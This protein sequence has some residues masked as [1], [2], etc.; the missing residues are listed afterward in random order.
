MMVIGKIGLGSGLHD[1]YLT[2]DEQYTHVSL[3]CLVCAP[4]LIGCPIDM[5]DEFTLNL[6]TND[7][8]LEVSQ[9]LLGQAARRM[10]QDGD[11][12][13]WAKPMEDGL[14]VVGFFNRDDYVPQTAAVKLSDLKLKGSCVVRD[15]WRQKDLGTFGDQFSTEVPVHGVVLVRVKAK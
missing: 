3:W 11:K 4:L 2:P 7:E 1:S 10:V 9:Y 13:V 8:V 15:L 5:L 12:E 6:L 14:F